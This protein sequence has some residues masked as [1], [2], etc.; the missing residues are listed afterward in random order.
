VSARAAYWVFRRELHVMLRA[1][2]MFVF[3]GV[4]LAVQGLAF[5]AL[6]NALSDPRRPAPLGALL[7]GQLAGTLL[8]WVLQLVVLTLLGMRAIADDKRSG[9]WELLLTAQVGEGAA[10]VGKW[11]AAVTIYA[12][13]W[14]PTLLYLVVVAVF[15]VD[16][17]GW[18]PATIATGYAGAIAVGAALLAWAI[19]ASAATSSTL[20]AGALGFALLVG[21]FLVGELPALWPALSAQHPSIGAAL[22]AVSLRGTSSAF[23]RG[24]ITVAAL[25]VIA[26]LALVGLSLAITLA[27]AGRRRRG[28]V[29]TRAAATALLA[30]CGVLAGALA[31]RNPARLDVSASRRNSLDPET[32]ALLAELPG[33]A[34]L[35]IVR[36]TLG[37]LDPIY[38]EVARVVRRMAEASPALRVREVDPASAPGGLAAIARA[39]G[40]VP[41]DL[42][43]GGAVIVDV[44]PAGSEASSGTRR[45]VIDV[46]SL[47]TL[48][49]DPAGAPTVEQLA[50]E[51][52]LGGAL[53]SLSASAPVTVCATTGHGELPVATA[54]PSSADWTTV[55]ARLAGEGM[56]VEEVTLDAGVPARCNVLVVAGPAQPLSSIEALAVQ[57]YLR[58]G[59]ALLVA[60]ASRAITRPDAPP[61]A[62]GGGLQPTGLEA[63]L[64]ADGLGLPLAIVVDPSLTVRELPGAL[65]VVDGYTEHPIN[66]GFPGTRP[67]LWFQP[68]AVIA[69][70][71]AR[72]LVTATA[73]SWGER[74]LVT[75][76]PVRETT[77]LA[78]PVA[79][80]ALGAS[81]TIIA[82]GS[83]ESMS[84]A[85]LAGGASAGDLWVARA[86]RFLSGKSEPRVDI[87]ARAPDQI[88]LVLTDAQRQAV[89]VTCV[90]VIPLAWTLLGGLVVWWRRRR[91]A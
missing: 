70:R 89:I 32:V 33:P 71:G 87:A 64:A 51:Q 47:A 6:V 24:E 43:S 58:A 80:A 29:R 48:D 52:A 1:P 23:A 45:R 90:G 60:A 2:I 17:G 66:H 53:A 46:F 54:D 37:E 22:A 63:V 13:L 30:V 12:L 14:I 44:T 67:T 15:R 78:G 9:G 36:P 85:V 77:D 65:F 35:T 20:G 19:A 4:F 81:G 69:E 59:G 76:P 10:V 91:R 83:A 50:V 68:R 21:L 11:L 26:A 5:A 55:A 84:T 41:G 57:R 82:T 27:C 34:T 74:D 86:I 42:A 16:S 31:V 79:L 8:T 73:A 18:D 38:D 75:A 25:V 7:E 28:E 40:V 39:A 62:R 3:G 49:R 56:T 61:H 72:P 88:R